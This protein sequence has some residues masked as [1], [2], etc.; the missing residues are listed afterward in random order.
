MNTVWAG[1]SINRATALLACL[2]GLAQ[3]QDYLDFAQSISSY[4]YFFSHLFCNRK[5]PCKT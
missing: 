5:L 4:M 3:A 1:V 2:P